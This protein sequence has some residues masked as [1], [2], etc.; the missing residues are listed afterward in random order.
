MPRPQTVTVTITMPA[1]GL[2]PAIRD[3][4][5]R[6]GRSLGADAAIGEAVRVAGP[7]ATEAS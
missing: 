3:E 4:R 1:M 5:E 6:E 7:A 2:Y